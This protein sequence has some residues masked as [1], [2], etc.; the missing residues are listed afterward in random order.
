MRA[1]TPTSAAERWYWRLVII[2]GVVGNVWLYGWPSLSAAVR[3]PAI[4]LL[5]AMVVI[6]AVVLIRDDRRATA[7][8]IARG[9]VE[10]AQATLPRANNVTEDETQRHS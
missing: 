2:A 9:N 4:V 10:A 8:A 1:L 5:G 3:I 7:A 6:A